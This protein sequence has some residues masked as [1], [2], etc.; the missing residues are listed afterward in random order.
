MQ[1]IRSGNPLACLVKHKYARVRFLVSR[2]DLTP[3]GHI[4]LPDQKKDMKVFLVRK[5]WLT[6]QGNCLKEQEAKD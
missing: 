5:F 4:G 1:R 3:S 6:P 2:G